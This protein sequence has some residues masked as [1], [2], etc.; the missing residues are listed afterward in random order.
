MS[1]N[2]KRYFLKYLREQH[3]VIKARI[4]SAFEEIATAE[5]TCE[6]L[7]SLIDDLESALF[8]NGYERD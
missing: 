2:D 4:R 5:Q 7:K 3:R 1:E 6:N 8:P